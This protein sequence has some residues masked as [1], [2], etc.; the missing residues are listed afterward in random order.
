MD[1]SKKFQPVGKMSPDT[2]GKGRFFL[3]IRIPFFPVCELTALPNEKKEESNHPDYLLF[4]D[5]NKV[6][7][8]Y[9]NE[10]K[11]SK[12]Y[13]SGQVFCMASPSSFLGLFIF[14]KP[15]VDDKEPEWEI[16]I[17]YDTGK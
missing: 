15:K 8:L 2:K 12:K 7:S 10:D 14:Q 11:N 13:Y 17:P 16:K 4:L 3:T 1:N 9:A 6:G 5:G